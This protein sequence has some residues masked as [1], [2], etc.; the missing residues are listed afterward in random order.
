M[1]TGPANRKIAMRN[2]KNGFTLVELMFALVIISI[3]VVALFEMF[4]QGSQ[5]IT[6]EYHRRIGL[7]KAQ[8]KMEAMKY[9]ET[10]LD[11]VPRHM[12]GTYREELLP[13]EHGQEAGIEA[14]YTIHIDPSL[15]VNRSGVPLNYLVWIEYNWTERSGK[16]QNVTFHTYF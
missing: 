1:K 10:E 13:P 16:R 3:S 6:E 14:E 12:A 11:S 4:A 15:H 5:L 8:A 9:F 2:S 7:E